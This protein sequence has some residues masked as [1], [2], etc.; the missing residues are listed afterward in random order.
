MAKAAGQA[1]GLAVGAAVGSVVG[2]PAAGAAL[3]GSLVG[4]AQERGA[5]K[6]QS[7]LDTAALELNREQAREQAAERSAIHA[8]KFRNALASQ[9]ALASMR[10][11]SG[12]LVKAFGNQAYKTFLQDEQAISTGLEISEIQGDISQANIA[13]RDEGKELKAI[14]RLTSSAFEGINTN[15]L[16]SREDG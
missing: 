14:S 10:G 12:S 16:R 1:A 8:T 9:V 4:F 3:G 5:Q 7:R 13:A 2:Q 15:I 11:G 6:E